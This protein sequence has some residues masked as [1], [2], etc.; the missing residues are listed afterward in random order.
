MKPPDRVIRLTKLVV[1]ESLREGDG[2]T[3]EALAHDIGR[4]LTLAG[5]GL[6]VEVL[7]CSGAV[8]FRLALEKLTGEARRGEHHPMLHIECHGNEEHGLEFTDGTMV[9]WLELAALLR[10][11]NEATELGLVVSVA[12]CFGIGA[13]AGVNPLHPAPCFALI[14]PTKG[15]WSNELY[16]AL[17]TFYLDMTCHSGPTM[18]MEKLTNTP[19]E[20]GS[21]VVMT[22]HLWFWNVTGRYLL[23]NATGQGLK[24][25]ALRLHQMA[26]AEG[27][28]KGLTFW[29]R[30]Y[31]GTLP[32]LLRQYHARFFM[33][34]QFPHLAV[35]FAPALNRIENELQRMGLA[36]DIP[37]PAKRAQKRPRSGA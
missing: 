7:R 19:L 15:I 34:E 14:G 5:V 3:G 24:A 33:T 9:S 21:F 25:Q 12:A 22:A 35:H 30:H 17:K 18:A 26:K 31:I 10:P 36:R 2:N 32:G 37:A 11:L 4:E 23:M 16:G 27:I 8:G 6:G 28:D 29:K 1:I 13:I 20:S